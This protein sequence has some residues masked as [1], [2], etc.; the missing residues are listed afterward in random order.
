MAIQIS[1]QLMG[2]AN[3]HNSIAR[4]NALL[5]QLNPQL[6][7][8]V[9]DVDFKDAPPLLFG[10]NFGTLA[11]ERIEAAAALTKTLGLEKSRQDFQKSHP[12]KKWGRGGGG[13]YS[14]HYSKQKGWKGSGNKA[15]KQLS[16]MTINN[17]LC[18]YTI[19][20]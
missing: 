6:K 15:T 16:S 10:E 17:K 3:Q 2:N 9:E 20:I 11:K 12:Q 14:G 19:F 4:R 8:L 5:T 13:Q 18:R 7:Q 1:L